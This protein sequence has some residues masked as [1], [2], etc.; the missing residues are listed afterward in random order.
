MTPTPCKPLQHAGTTAAPVLLPETADGTGARRGGGGQGGVGQGAPIRFT[1]Y[2]AARPQ[3]SP[4]ALVGKNGRAFVT[5]DK[6][7]ARGYRS[8]RQEVSRE[9][10]AVAP[11]TPLDEPVGVWFWVFVP[12]PKN[13]FGTGR[14]AAV[15]KPA[16]PERPST[17]IDLDKLQRCL[18]DAGTGILWRDDSR[19]AEWHVYRRYADEGPE[20]I[21]VDVRRL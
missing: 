18:G 16:A 1:V 9:M 12:R 15:L 14:N 19:I 11:A 7:G 8:W 3:G 21:I 5:E 20:R 17:G 4:R 6:R 2:G 13:Q 10:L